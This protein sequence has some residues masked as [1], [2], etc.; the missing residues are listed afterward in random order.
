[1]FKFLINNEVNVDLMTQIL[2]LISN[3][4]L[5]YCEADKQ[6]NTFITQ[7]AKV[8]AAPQLCARRNELAR[9][10]WATPHTRGRQPGAYTHAPLPLHSVGIGELGM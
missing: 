10:G 3:F 2:Q 6:V 1:M 5:V 7:S 9:T 4:K 8:K